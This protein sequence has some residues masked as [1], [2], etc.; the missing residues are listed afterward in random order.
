M[1]KLGSMIAILTDTSQEEYKKELLAYFKTYL[2]AH[3]KEVA[4]SD[5]SLVLEGERTMLREV[6]KFIENN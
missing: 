2:E 3:K 1:I 6:I 5:Y 4:M